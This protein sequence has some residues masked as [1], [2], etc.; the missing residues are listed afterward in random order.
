[1]LRLLSAAVAQGTEVENTTTEGVLASYTFEENFFKKGKVVHFEALVKVLDNN[2]TDTLVV[3]ARLGGT[4]L[5]GTAIVTTSAVDVS[6]DDICVVRGSLVCRDN[7][8]ASGTI[9]AMAEANDPDAAGQAT[10]SYGAVVSSLDLTADLL[11]EITAEWSVA[12]ADNEVAAEAFN[13]FEVV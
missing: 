9:V 3:R 4:T 10:E 1:M 2:S 11:L 5:T 6:D 13:V 7:P 8:T 12:H